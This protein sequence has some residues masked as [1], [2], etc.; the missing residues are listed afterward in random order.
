MQV[1]LSPAPKHRALK[2]SAKT[3]DLVKIYLQE[4]SRY[5]LLT[6]DEEITLGHQVQA[7]M[8]L[9]A[10]KARLEKETDCLV[11]DLQWSSHAQLSLEALQNTLQQG[12]Q[13]KKKMI[14][15]NLR[16]VVSIAKKYQGRDLDFLDLIQ[17][18]S[19]GLERGVEKFDPCRGYKLSTY[20]YWWI[21]QGITRAIANQSRSIRLPI[22][23]TERFNKIKRTQ[24]ELTQSLGRI[25]T[26][27]EVASQ[28]QL[29]L[30][31]IKDILQLAKRPVSLDMPV[32]DD[33]TSQFQDCLE[34][35]N[36]GPEENV[37]DQLRNSELDQ[38]LAMLS[39]QAQSVIR[40]RFG[41]ADGKTYT[42]QEIGQHLGI[43]RERVRQVQNQALK[44]LRR[45]R[46]KLSDY[47][48]R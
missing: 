12:K 33:S 30:S 32:G 7:M 16:L 48:A 28:L 17:E 40:L 36:E 46:D 15:S 35:S 45:R 18:G 2:S 13:A 47:L 20:A 21:R 38:S 37:E 3:T 26:L 14:E 11:S 1:T 42:L 24:R 34:S 25:P 27:Q 41:L 4:I 9:L 10:A 5:S 44:S 23:I 39:E 8:H 19:L 29:P 31:D 22:H 43:S 6:P